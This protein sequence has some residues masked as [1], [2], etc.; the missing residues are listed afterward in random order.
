M[1]P[2]QNRHILRE[3]CPPF[4]R[5]SQAYS[6]LSEGIFTLY[7]IDAELMWQAL[8]ARFPSYCPADALPYLAADRRII[9]GP[10]ETE[11]ATRTRLLAWM[12]EA[13]LSGLP[14]GW[15]IALQA[16]GAPDYPKVRL[17]TKSSVWYT[18][19]ANAVPRMLRFPGYTPLD[20]CPYES[21]AS[22][23]IGAVA[24]ETE[25]LRCSALYSRAKASPANFD[26]DSLSNPERAACWWDAVGVIYGRYAEQ[27]PYADLG[28]TWLL[29]DPGESVGFDEGYGTFTALRYLSVQR[30]SC[31]SVLRAVVWTD[32]T[33]LF[34]PTKSLGDPELPDG[35][36]GRPGRIVAGHLT[37][38]R[39]LDCRVLTSFPRD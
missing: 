17:V 22:W 13:V 27:E 28:D 31:K 36:W 9:I 20:P 4:L 37:P 2:R 21:G 11:A 30:K 8:L 1:A 25:R 32:N 6:F 35:Y 29:D 5:G 23:P 39:S 26:W 18:L 34:D 7:D 19:E 33:T 12:L 16:F 10:E 3:L 15:L 24:S 14:I 38:T